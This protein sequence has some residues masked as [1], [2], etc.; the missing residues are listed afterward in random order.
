MTAHYR[1]IADAELALRDEQFFEPDAIHGQQQDGI[2]QNT[3]EAVDA[4]VAI[5]RWIGIA[6]ALTALALIAVHVVPRAIAG[7]VHD[8]DPNCDAVKCVMPIGEE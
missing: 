8:A 4:A 5:V 1:E 6:I 3:E 7:A 2:H